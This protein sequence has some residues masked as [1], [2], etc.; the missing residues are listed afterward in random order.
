MTVKSVIAAECCNHYR[1]GPYGKANWCVAKDTVCPIFTPTFYRCP[2]FEK[3]VLPAWTDVAAEWA[4]MCGQEQ[5]PE[6][7][8][9]RQ[10]ICRNCGEAFK[11]EN[12]QQECCS[13]ACQIEARKR[14]VRAYRRGKRKAVSAAS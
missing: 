14:Y 4:D 2:W 5:L 13:E 10:A 3:A 11:A 7:T 8:V 9:T 1:E 6:I 12:N